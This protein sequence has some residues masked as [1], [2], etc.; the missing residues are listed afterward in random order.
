MFNLHIYNHL[1]HES[2]VAYGNRSLRKGVAFKIFYKKYINLILLYF[3]PV[4]E[5]VSG[6]FCFRW[7]EKSAEERKRFCHRRQKYFY[8]CPWNEEE[9]FLRS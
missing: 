7:S 9:A 5:G 8:F 2:S 6:M 1:R 4:S 3:L